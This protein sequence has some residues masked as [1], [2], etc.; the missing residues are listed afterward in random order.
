MSLG[1]VFSHSAEA[2]SAS[3]K[4]SESESSNIAS[5]GF[6]LS[7]IAYSTSEDV[8]E[9]INGITRTS[10]KTIFTDRFQGEG[11]KK[12]LKFVLKIM[13]DDI[14]N[15][16]FDFF[17][18]NFECNL[19]EMNGKRERNWFVKSC[20]EEYR[21]GKDRETSLKLE[22]LMENFVKTLLAQ[23][24]F[25]IGTYITFR[26]SVYKSITEA[27]D[28]RLFAIQCG[29]KTG[30][31]PY[32][33]SH[34]SI[35]IGPVRFHRTTTEN[36]TSD[37]NMD[38]LKRSNTHYAYPLLLPDLRELLPALCSYAWT[39]T[40]ED[41]SSYLSNLENTLE[42]E[43]SRMYSDDDLKKVCAVAVAFSKKSYNVVLANC[44]SYSQSILEAFSI[45][46]PKYEIEAT[47]INDYFYSIKEYGLRC[48][49]KLGSTPELFWTSVCRP[50]RKGKHKENAQISAYALF[51]GCHFYHLQQQQS[52]EGVV[53]WSIVNARSRGEALT[54]MEN[55]IA[56]AA[57]WWYL[58]HS[59]KSNISILS[60][61]TWNVEQLEKMYSNLARVHQERKAALDVKSMNFGR[62]ELFCPPIPPLY[63]CD[64]YDSLL[65]TVLGN[66]IPVWE[67]F[68]DEK[69]PTL[70]FSHGNAE[71]LKHSRY[72]VEKLVKSFE[73]KSMN[74]N[75]CCY[76][77]TGYGRSV[78]AGRSVSQDTIYS[79]LASVL[80]YLLTRRRVKAQNIILYGRSIGAAPSLYAAAHFRSNNGEGVR[81][82]ILESGFVT[83][84]SVK[85]KNLKMNTLNGV[86]QQ[87]S[88]Y[89][90]V[91]GNSSTT[92]QSQNKSNIQDI[93]NNKKAVM[94]L[95]ESKVVCL[96]TASIY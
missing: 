77:Y 93:F 82:L 84:N 7:Q 81:A 94:M 14:D 74:L 45:K 37:Y 11:R 33:N 57:D 67:R 83:L 4:A 76:E 48:P 40:T 88:L 68:I 60:S 49:M 66:L 61:T 92:P 71:D 51:Q 16:Q 56:T 79:D 55:A 6:T 32:S 80:D 62:K 63:R 42:K 28:P 24:Y 44:H 1:K 2:L 10:A 17:V 70:V 52:G 78:S 53:P 27:T 69:Y 30:V 65:Q 43:F 34:S 96:A 26:P 35:L 89:G 36:A 25:L 41:P 58:R 29:M 21:N 31:S 22:K 91:A 95:R 19:K 90:V 85:L 75:V 39:S 8:R 9:Y 15:Y 20:K 13:L 72:Y 64:Q 23:R 18:R 54:L 38:S 5:L 47:W 59:E 12:M 73:T 50:D 87:N 46:F 3:S 86:P